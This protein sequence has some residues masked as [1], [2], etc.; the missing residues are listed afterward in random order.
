M[1]PEPVRDELDS[2]LSLEDSEL[3]LRYYSGNDLAFQVVFA[4]H[5]KRH[6]ALAQIVLRNLSGHAEDAVED[7]WLNFARTRGSRS[8]YTPER[9]FQI[10]IDA[11]VRNACRD[12]QRRLAS[13]PELTGTLVPN[14]AASPRPDP[15]AEAI[16]VEVLAL[17]RECEQRLA[18]KE[19]LCFR[20][21]DVLGHTIDEV[22][23]LTGIVTGSV[24]GYIQRARNKMR[25]CLRS[26][27]VRLTGVE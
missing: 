2:L 13:R 3:A 12:I 7:G 18:E 19:R 10:W 27:N 14:L 1:V 26:K 11:L 23:G 8:A 20:Y 15:E 6:I 24:R 4:R 25:E 16:S 17:A 9:P 21:F 5:R 22:A